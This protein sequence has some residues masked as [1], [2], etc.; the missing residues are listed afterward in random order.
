MVD[1]PFGF[2]LFEITVIETFLQP[3]SRNPPGYSLWVGSVL[4]E[5]AYSD[6]LIHTP[7]LGYSNSSTSGHS[8]W[9]SS[10]SDILY[11]G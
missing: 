8:C 4:L 1:L 10:S 6:S 2:Y 3:E 7:A 5:A 9:A 11:R